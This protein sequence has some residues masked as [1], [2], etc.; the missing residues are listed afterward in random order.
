[1]QVRMLTKASATKF[2]P[3]CKASSFFPQLRQLLSVVEDSN[4]KSF[5]YRHEWLRLLLGKC[6][7]GVDV[8]KPVSP[9]NAP[10]T[11]LTRSFSGMARR[12]SIPGCSWLTSPLPWLIL[13]SGRMADAA[14]NR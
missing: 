13:S 12:E 8:S 14:A 4:H 11:H 7:R 9:I 10:F 6:H 1:M 5:L 2:M 3:G